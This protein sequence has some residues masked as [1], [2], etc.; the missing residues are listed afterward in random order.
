MNHDT[1]T[2]DCEYRFKEAQLVWSEEFN[3]NTLNPNNWNI[4]QGGHGFGNGEWEYYTDRP[5]NIRIENQQLVIEI[6]KENFERRHYTSARINTVGKKEFTY[7][8]FEARIKVP[9]SKGIWPAFWMIGRNGKHWP[10][11]GE[12]DIMGK[13]GREP[14]TVHGTVHGPGYAGAYG[15]GEAYT[16]EEDFGNDFHIFAIE[17]QPEQI[18]W[19]VDGILFF[20]LQNIDLPKGTPWP[21]DH[22][23]AL[24]LNTAVGGSWPDYPDEETIL[25]QFMLVDW[26]RVYQSPSYPEKVTHP[27]STVPKPV[28]HLS[29]IQLEVMVLCYQWQVIGYA[30]ILDTNNQP[31]PGV[32]LRANFTKA[33]TE[34]I[35]PMK[36]ITDQNGWAG[37]FTSEIADQ[38]GEI[39][40]AIKNIEKPGWKLDVFGSI[41]NTK[42]VSH[43]FS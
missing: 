26:V 15:I 27:L 17:W 12:I 14:K 40:L 20:T 33:V 32:T 1:R 6:R 22:N 7:G 3:H 21:F 38:P 29:D 34:G 10:D 28:L 13:I 25:P 39:Q 35:G 23:H 16:I 24:L 43:L 5:E 19:F 36:H 18:Q 11:C 30:Q 8:R 37:P 9:V 2:T 41:E 4:V 31:V 42:T